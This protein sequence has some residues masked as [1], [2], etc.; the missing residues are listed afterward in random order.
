MSI[1]KVNHK[2]FAVWDNT[3]GFALFIGSYEHCVNY[4]AGFDQGR[5]D[6]KELA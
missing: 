1:Y 6:A 5:A 2:S 3:G 4:I